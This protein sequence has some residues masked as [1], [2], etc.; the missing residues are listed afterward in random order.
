MAVDAADIAKLRA[1]VDDTDSEQT[2]TDA[3]LEAAVL[4]QPLDDVNLIPPPQTGATDVP[5]EDSAWIPTYD[6][7]RAAADLWDQKAAKESGSYDFKQGAA[8][9]AFTRSQLFK[10]AL[11]MARHFRSLAPMKSVPLV[12]SRTDER[13]LKSRW[14]GYPALIIDPDVT[15]GGVYEG[16][17]QE[18]EGDF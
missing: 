11:R 12:I 2:Y 1:M 5:P 9:Q 8:G 7:H 4:A 16:E 6:L 3:D 17:F 15:H 14:G 13:S 10:Q 18:A